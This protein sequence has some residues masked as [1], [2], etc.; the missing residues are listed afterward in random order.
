M[1]HVSLH[2]HEK[3]LGLFFLII[4][5]QP[6]WRFW[7]E[8]INRQPQDTENASPE[9]QALPIPVIVYDDHQQILG[10]WDICIEKSGN[11]K[12]TQL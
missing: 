8:E 11:L 3:S 1:E 6:S 12:T 2:T 4:A 7:H 10:D 9:M 5:C